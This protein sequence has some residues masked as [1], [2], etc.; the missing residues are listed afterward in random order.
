MKRGSVVVAVAAFV[1]FALPLI[2]A[3]VVYDPDL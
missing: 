3:I 1:I 2:L